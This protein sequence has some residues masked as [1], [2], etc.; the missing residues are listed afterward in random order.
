MSSARYM[1]PCRQHTQDHV[2]TVSISKEDGEI[3]S[4]KAEGKLIFKFTNEAGPFMSDF[5]SW[6][7]TPDLG[8]KPEITGHGGR[9]IS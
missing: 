7:P 4:Q 8:L 5:S 6:G 3:L 2:P 9:I 1:R